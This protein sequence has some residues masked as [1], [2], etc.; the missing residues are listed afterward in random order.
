MFLLAVTQAWSPW[1]SSSCRVGIQPSIALHRRDLLV[2]LVDDHVFAADRGA[3]VGELALP[4]GQ[5]RLALVGLQIEVG[6]DDV[7][8]DRLEP[9]RLQVVVEDQRPALA[10]DRRVRQVVEVRGEDVAAAQACVE[11]RWGRRLR[12][13]GGCSAGARNVV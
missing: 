4:P 13:I 2:V 1:T 8:A 6:R 9:H 5:G 3:G 12:M 11:V 7:L 10:D